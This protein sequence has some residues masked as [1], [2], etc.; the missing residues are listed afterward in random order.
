MRLFSILSLLIA[1]TV[2]VAGCSESQTAAAVAVASNS[3]CPIMGSEVTDDGGRVT[4]DDET[5]GFCC[6]SCIEKWNAL[7]AEEKAEK[8]ASADSTDSDGHDHGEH[9]GHG[10]HGDEHDH[11]EHSDGETTETE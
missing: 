3:H 10:E 9:E 2:M 7:S 5:I 4:W 8:L 1:G 6:P 11:A